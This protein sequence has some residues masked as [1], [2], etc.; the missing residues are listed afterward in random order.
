MP[1]LNRPTYGISELYLFSY[2]Q[3]REAYEKAT[4]KTCPPWDKMRRPQR[5]EDPSAEDAAD[6]FV[7]YDSVLAVDMKTGEPL[8][9]PDGQPYTKRLILPKL[10]AA[11]VNIP[12]NG[13]NVEGAEV[14]EYPCPLRPLEPNEALYFGLL[15]IPAVK[16]T[17]L[18]D[19][20]SAGGF[21]AND[22]ALL[23]A[24]AKKLGV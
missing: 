5:W 2:Y 10:A 3:T 11:S 18:Y 24:I 4:G 6:D 15:G 21:T 16:N 19:A 20:Q 7:V 13:A 8:A 9:G 17:D 12:P 22:R 23:Q 14:P 1:A